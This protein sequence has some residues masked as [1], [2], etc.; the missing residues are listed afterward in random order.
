MPAIVPNQVRGNSLKFARVESGL[1]AQ[2]F[3]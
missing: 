2:R 1:Q 3:G